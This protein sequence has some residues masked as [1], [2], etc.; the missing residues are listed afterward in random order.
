MDRYA[1]IAERVAR[2]RSGACMLALDRLVQFLCDNPNATPDDFLAWA[3]TLERPMEGQRALLYLGVMA[4]RFVN[5]GKAVEKGINSTD[6][7]PDEMALGV[8][9]ELEHT[10]DPFMA[11]MIALDHLAEIPDYYTRLEKMEEEAGVEH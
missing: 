9:V 3:K 10:P 7:D 1:K 8:K 6:V 4:S 5:G 2:G 11:G